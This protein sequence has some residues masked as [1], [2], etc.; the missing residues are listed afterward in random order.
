MSWPRAL[1]SPPP[2]QGSGFPAAITTNQNRGLRTTEAG[3][4]LGATGSREMVLEAGL[5]GGGWA[6]VLSLVLPPAWATPFFSTR[7]PSASG[8]R[9]PSHR[10]W[11]LLLRGLRLLGPWPWLLRGGPVAVNASAQVCGALGEGQAPPCPLG[12]ETTTLV[13]MTRTHLFEIPRT[14]DPGRGGNVLADSP[15]QPRS[16][17]RVRGPGEPRCPRS[18]LRS[19][20]L[21]G[22]RSCHGP[23]FCRLSPRQ[24]ERQ[25]LS[26]AEPGLG[27]PEGRCGEQLP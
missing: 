24:N 19:H 11:S 23:V 14:P 16:R 21:A 18:S 22:A 6:V 9:G 8:A 15:E 25:D 20:F 10:T 17:E 13:P 12:Q 1:G 4:L 5:R 26:Q 2:A 3:E 7:L 27:Y